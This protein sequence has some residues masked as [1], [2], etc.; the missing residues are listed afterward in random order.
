MLDLWGAKVLLDKL[1]MFDI[2]N[3]QIGR[4]TVSTPE[5]S[6]EFSQ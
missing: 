2:L 1:L 5:I 3:L 6:D 4:Q